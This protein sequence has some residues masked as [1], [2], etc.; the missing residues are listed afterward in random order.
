MPFPNTR[1]LKRQEPFGQEWQGM[2]AWERGSPDFTCDH[3]VKTMRV[4]SVQ[5][6]MEDRSKEENV[7]YALSMLDRS[8]PSDLILLPEIWPCGFLC[9][10]RY[11]AESESVDGPLVTS[12]REW[13]AA[14]GCYL[15]MGSFVEREGEHL[16]NTT[17]FLNPEGSIIGTYRKIHLFGYRSLEKDLLTRGAGVTVVKTPWGLAGLSTC[18]DLRFPEFYRRM[19]DLGVRF[20]LVV[21]AWPRI[22]LEAWNL[23][24]RTRAL[25]NLSYLFSCN[26]AGS[27]RGQEYAGHS[28]L[29]DPLGNVITQGD[30]GECHVSAEIDP[31]FVARTRKDFRVLSDRVFR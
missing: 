13:A 14:R 12:F 6:K 2:I 31:D 7:R 1:G 23:F 27:N 28:T 15:L 11:A 19:L 22:R 20:F 25:E 29:V 16:F 17:L 10:D 26:C 18:Y 3:G 9:F 5:L 4:T 8:P 21:S 30:D 24:N